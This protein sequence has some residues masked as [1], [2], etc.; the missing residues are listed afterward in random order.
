MIGL[1]LILRLSLLLLLSMGLLPSAIAASSPGLDIPESRWGFNGTAMQD[2]VCPLSLLLHNKASTPFDGAITLEEIQGMGSRLG[3]SQVQNVYLSP[4]QMRWLQFFPAPTGMGTEWRIQWGRRADES[5]KIPP[6]KLGPSARVFLLDAESPYGGEIRLKTFPD[7]L[8]PTSVGATDSLRELVMEHAPKWESARWQALE[9]WVKVGGILHICKGLDG[10]WPVFP[11]DRTGLRAS[12]PDSDTQAATVHLSGLGQIVYHPVARIGITEEYLKKAGYAETEKPV[13]TD[14]TSNSYGRSS[15]THSI[16]GKLTATTRAKISWPLIFLLTIL[17]LILAGPVHY[18]WAKKVDYRVAILGFLGLIALFCLLLGYFGR[19]GSG[20]KSSMNALAIARPLGGGRY[21]ASQWISA[22]AVDGN[23]Y[24]LSHGDGIHLYATASV[25]D[26][27]NGRLINGRNGMFDVDIP[28]YSSRAF[29]YR[30]VLMGPEFPCAIN[31]NGSNTV[32]SKWSLKFEAPLPE[33]TK[34]YI[35]RN[36][37]IAEMTER[38][39]EWVHLTSDNLTDFVKKTGGWQNY[40]YG[41]Y[42]PE[43]DGEWWQHQCAE[44]A[45]ATFLDVEPEW[46]R[47]NT[48]D[49]AVKTPKG[50]AYVYLLAP[51][52]ET[53]FI[54]HKSFRK[55]AGRVLYVLSVSLTQPA[56]PR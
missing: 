7:V 22:F 39:G 10:K 40:N 17:Y 38:D 2:R 49:S 11:P 9:D 42:N 35:Q 43:Q 4:G 25:D 14:L 5:L 51:M 16:L 28:L 54:Q 15:W 44:V 32:L 53:F 55:H 1:R 23:R 46:R 50:H 29:R 34:V 13:D 31:Q 36:A 52:P 27:V 6:P 45:I 8:F 24:Q 47:G 20:E 12:A 37:D 19:R 30:G 33:G 3:A 18:F 41:R 21:D 26:A 56:F 48:K